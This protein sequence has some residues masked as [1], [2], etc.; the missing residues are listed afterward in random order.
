[1]DALLPVLPRRVRRGLAVIS[2]LAFVVLLLIFVVYGVQMFQVNMTQDAPSLLMIDT[3]WLRG[4]P[5]RMGWPYLAIPVG[6]A[7]TICDLV[8]IRLEARGWQVV[9]DETAAAFR[10]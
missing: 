7:L 3:D 6:A 4:W 1:M 2:D 9:G 10:L 8:A 5:I